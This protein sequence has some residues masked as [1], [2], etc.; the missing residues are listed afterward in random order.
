[1]QKILLI[2]DKYKDFEKMEKNLNHFFKKN[3]L[4]LENSKLFLDAFDPLANKYCQKNKC[5]KNEFTINFESKYETKRLKK[6]S[7]FIDV[8]IIF[9]GKEKQKT[10]SYE[11]LA[12]FLKENN[13]KFII[14]NDENEIVDQNNPTKETENIKKIEKEEIKET[15]REEKRLSI[16]IDIENLMLNYQNYIFILNNDINPQKFTLEVNSITELETFIDSVKECQGLKAG[17][18]IK[19]VKFTEKFKRIDKNILYLKRIIEE[20]FTTETKPLII[21]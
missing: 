14:L 18:I 10:F 11:N 5:K 6:L 9:I 4:N 8:A 19:C 16:E 17:F 13:K 3:N 7:N 12:K 21:Y 1:M 20:E 2:T 15:P